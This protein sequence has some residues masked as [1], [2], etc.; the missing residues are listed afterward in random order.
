MNNCSMPT[1]TQSPKL[2]VVCERAVGIVEPFEQTRELF[3]LRS[4][5]DD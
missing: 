4:C 3:G 1:P 2:N 5:D